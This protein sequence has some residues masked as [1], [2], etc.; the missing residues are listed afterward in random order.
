[1][2]SGSLSHCMVH[3]QVENGGMAG[4]ANMLNKQSQTTKKGGSPA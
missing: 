1:V 2:I 4:A 3:P